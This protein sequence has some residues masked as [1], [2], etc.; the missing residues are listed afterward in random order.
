MAIS[1]SGSLE[2]TGSLTVTG[3]INMSG[4]IASSSYASNTELLDGR[5]SLTFANTGSNSFV[6]SQN[7]N[8]TVAI[9]GSLTTTGAITAQSINVQQV[10]SSVVYSS[11][12]NVFGNNLS[13]TQVMTGSVDISGSLS[14]NGTTDLTGVLTG[15]T[16]AFSGLLTA[17]AVTSG[18]IINS[19]VAY[20]FKNESSSDI[21]LGYRIK[22]T[23]ANAVDF[24]MYTPNGTTGVSI[25]GAPITFGSAI[26]GT[27]A[28]FNTPTLSGAVANS[29][30]SQPVTTTHYISHRLGNGYVTGRGTTGE[31]YISSNTDLF[32]ATI[33][34]E[35][36]YL[37]QN[38]GIL[39]YFNAPSVS[40]GA[41]PSFVE[42]FSINAAGAA[43]FSSTITTA[44][45]S[46]GT[47]KPFKIGNVATVTPTSQNRTIEIEIDGTTY[48]LTAKTTND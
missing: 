17:G 29:I 13:N 24:Y 48:Y 25:V 39:I 31:T 43:T 16:A 38:A 11:G 33:T 41:T 30:N 28:T 14:V 5:D 47:A 7:I 26:T 40:A 23:G 9:T 10:T 8:G 20:G 15:T 45:P 21:D 44:A 4:S 2:L 34:G 22:R 3:G 42:R 32:T 1:L 35:S 19:S 6:G 46:G 36:S 37:V 12:S 18:G 27:S